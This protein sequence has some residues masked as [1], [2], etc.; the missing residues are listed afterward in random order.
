[1]KIE[2]NKPLALGLSFLTVMIAGVI[3]FAVYAGG[4][5]EMSFSNSAMFGPNTRTGFGQFGMVVFIIVVF[6][7]VRIRSKYLGFIDEDK[8]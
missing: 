7:L 1:M 2:D 6:I 8:N 3:L 5:F 4:S